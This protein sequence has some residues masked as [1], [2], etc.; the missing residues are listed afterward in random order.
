[1]LEYIIS[2]SNRVAEA[3]RHANKYVVTV[4]PTELGPSYIR[5]ADRATDVK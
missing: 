4:R 3:S 5:I 1:M 2:L